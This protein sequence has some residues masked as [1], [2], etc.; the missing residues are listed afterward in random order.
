MAIIRISVEEH[1]ALGP[2]ISLTSRSINYPG[3]VRKRRER[4]DR[5]ISGGLLVPKFIQFNMA[6]RRNHGRPTRSAFFELFVSRISNLGRR[7]FAAQWLR[8]PGDRSN[9]FTLTSGFNF[10]PFS[11]SFPMEKGLDENHDSVTQILR[12]HSVIWL[13]GPFRDPPP[14]LSARSMILAVCFSMESHADRRAWRT[15]VSY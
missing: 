7:S 3:T 8:S 11:A 9:R 4:R 5:G 13:A 14:P 6:S 10:C 15:R 2:P 1:A 12:P